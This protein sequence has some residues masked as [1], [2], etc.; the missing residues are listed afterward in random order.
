[1]PYSI[2]HLHLNFF[3]ILFSNKACIS[4]EDQVLIERQY[5]QK[6]FGEKFV[7]D[8]GQ[9]KLEFFEDLYS[10]IEPKERNLL[11]NDK[12]KLINKL[13]EVFETRLRRTRILLNQQ[14][15]DNTLRNEII[16][17]N[18]EGKLISKLSNK[19]W[20][21]FNLYEINQFYV[22][23]E[24]N[25][26]NKFVDKDKKGKKIKIDEGKD[27]LK[28]YLDNIYYLDDETIAKRKEA[29]QWIDI[30]VKTWLNKQCNSVGIEYKGK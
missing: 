22:E 26:V 9:I 15:M 11:D 21:N 3:S 16:R 18:E 8:I 5:F 20:Q 13:L 24:R 23:V 2:S 6:Y 7:E 1:M 10:L 4:K 12:K 27:E 28:G 29:I 19:K 14:F 17:F 25:K 30:Q